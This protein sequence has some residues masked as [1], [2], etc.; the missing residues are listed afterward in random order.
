MT[1]QE[2]IALLRGQPIPDVDGFAFGDEA[3]KDGDVF[4]L[5][6]IRESDG[7]SVGTA[8]GTT[9]AEVIERAQAIARD[10]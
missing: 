7:A 3:R 8:R 6:V 9:A 2:E 1:E 4:D 5:D 10:D